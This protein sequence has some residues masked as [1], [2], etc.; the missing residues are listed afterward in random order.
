MAPA[1]SGTGQDP[2]EVDAFLGAVLRAVQWAR[3]NRRVVTIGAVIVVVAIAAAVYYQNYRAD[4]RRQAATQLQQLQGNVQ[5]G[6]PPDTLARSVRTFVDRYGD[7]RYGDEGRLIMARIHLTNG[8]W[9]EAVDVLGPVASSYPADVPIGYAARTLLAAAHEGAG[10]TERAL[11]TYAELAANAQFA[12]QRHEAAA[13][14]ARLLAEQGRLSE[15][16]KVLA[17]LVAEADTASGGVA[18]E[19]LRE[20]RLQL[21]EVRARLSN[22]TA[23]ADSAAGGPGAVAG[24]D[25][26]GAA[27]DP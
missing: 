8:N 22:S 21:G 1:S 18:S 13:D 7:T 6:T 14:R 19:D 26:S 9:Q 4:V 5:A 10:N 2:E 24:P 16:E 25:S 12:F 3:E 17:R 23:S 15:A 11:E 20:Y 27:M